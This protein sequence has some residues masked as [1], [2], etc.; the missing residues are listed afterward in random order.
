MGSEPVTKQPK[1]FCQ[2]FAYLRLITLSLLDAS[3]L[4]HLAEVS[5]KPL[6]L[7]PATSSRAF[8]LTFKRVGVKLLHLQP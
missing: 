2:G 7:L 8:A 5:L 3:T 1:S 6:Q 4:G